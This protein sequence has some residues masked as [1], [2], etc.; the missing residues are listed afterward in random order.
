MAEAHDLK[1]IGTRPVRPDGVEKVTGRANF[2]A[3]LSLPGMI[4]GKVLRSPYAHARIKSVDVS[5]ALAMEGVLAAVSGSDFAEQ[6]DDLGRN[7]IA[8]DKALYHGHAVAAVAATTPLL[9]E[10]ALD[11]IKVDYDVLEP[12]LSIDQAI[13]DGAT[14][15][16]EEMHTNGDASQPA[17]NVAAITKFERG[18]AEKGFAEADVVVEGEFRV[19]MAHQGYIEPHACTATINEEGKI[20]VWCST[21]GHFDVRTQTAAILG[22]SISKIKV[23]ASEI[24]GGFGGKLSVYLEPLAVKLSELSNRPVRMVMNREEVFRATGPTSGTWCKAKVGAKKDG[25]ITAAT[26]W[27]SYEA[28]AFPGAPVGP[29]CMSVLAPYDLENF[30]IEGIDVLVNKPKVAAY[31]APGA[32]QAM[33]AME[34]V[35]DDLARELGMDPIDLRLKNAADE[36]TQAPYGPKFPAIG[37]K[38]CLEAAKAHPNYTAPVP[39]GC[40]RGV[41]CG[42]WFNIGMQSSAEVLIRED[43]TVI[44]NEGSP[45]I[46]GSRASMCLMAAETLGIPYDRINAHVAD[47]EST[48]YCNMTGGSRTTFATGMAVVQA[49]EDIIAQCKERAAMTWDIDAD[50]V[51]WD[52]GQAVPKPGVNA[53]VDPLSLA[54]IARTWGRTG[55]PILGR[56]SVN[57]QGAGAGFSVNWTDLAV[58]RETG[59]VDVKAYTA[60]QDAGRAIHPAYV[61]GQ[62]Q[63]G[64]AQGLGWALNEEYIYD[65]NGVMENAGFLD[66]RVPVASDLPMIDTQIVEVPNP[67]HPYGVRGVG[68]TP[69]TAPLA[70]T[71]NAVRDA[72]GFRV[73]ELPMSPPRLLEAI[74]SQE[75]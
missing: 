61:E 64:A 28:G 55:G 71:S 22:T 33:H 3:D 62:M 41:A 46:G 11:A 14:L 68:E 70:A 34:C 36:G 66:Y 60:I 42:F 37:L 58:D 40:G 56:A 1:V 2:G 4:H 65:D 69:I 51:D 73:S 45:D 50:Q 23:I 19:P 43:G 24:G 35:I 27:L 48:G 32:P 20:T 39:E 18:D 31:R 13:A 74:D 16:N 21:Q 75:G 9:A 12:V 44:I 57:A 59:K 26:A 25:T 6:T 38:A 30:S 15:V 67:T 8:R 10:Q 5:G 72:L 52:D 49:C 53:D 47:T 54:D 63:G 29:G 17:S 7:V